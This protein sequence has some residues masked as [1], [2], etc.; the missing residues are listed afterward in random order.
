[1]PYPGAHR[2]PWFHGAYLQLF[3]TTTTLVKLFLLA[4]RPQVPQGITTSNN[5]TDNAEPLGL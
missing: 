4:Y 2:Q 5:F 3:D 1:M